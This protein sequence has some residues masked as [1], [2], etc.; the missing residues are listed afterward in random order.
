MPAK[1]DE[2]RSKVIEVLNKARSM[3][4]YAIIQ[5]LN[6]HYGLDDFD[7]G[8]LA[9]EVKKIAIEE[10]KHAEAFA[11]RIKDLD[12]EPTAQ[13]AST[14]THGQEVE[15]IFPFDADVEAGTLGKYNEFMK[16]CRE[17]NDS[18]SATLFETI[19]ADEQ[20]HFDYFD[21][22]DAHIKKL[23]NSFLARMVSGAA[24]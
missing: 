8:Q 10:M 15:K 5:Y 9:S 11:E 6:Q 18:I 20:R 16:I 14:I 23:G 13:I 24:D 7:Y 21:D 2:Q 17:N 3:E 4:L 1:K 22:T 19:I 12:G